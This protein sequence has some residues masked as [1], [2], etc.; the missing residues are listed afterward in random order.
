MAEETDPDAPLRRRMLALGAFWFL[1]MGPLGL[2]LPYYGL[3]LR[4]NAGLSGSEVGAI[5]A[6][7]PLVAMAGQTLWGVTADRSGM[8]ARVLVVLCGGCAAGYLAVGAAGGFLALIGATALLA[9]FQRSLIPLSLSVS[10]PGLADH[11]HAFGVVRALGTIGFGVAMFAFPTLLARWQGAHGL[12]PVAGGPSQPGLGLL[13]P[14][15]AG[16]AGAAALAALALPRGGVLALR[17]APGDWRALLRHRP[18]R[19]LLLVCAAAFLFQNG[20]LEIFPIFVRSRGG[21]LDTLRSLWLFMLVPEVVGV[22]L[23]GVVTGRL[24]PRAL[25]VFGVAAGGLRWLGSAEVHSLSWL[26]PLQSLHAAVVVGL[27]LGGP[28]YLDAIV[29]P[30]LRSTAQALL[31]VAAV[32]LGGASS[33]LLSGWLLQHAGPTAPYVVAGAG[34]LLLAA[35]IPRVLPALAVPAEEGAAG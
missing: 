21:D 34:S 4:E 25:L 26:H 9:V 5:F 20:P 32:G 13:F 19:R 31:G 1:M 29:P 35:A 28:L 14:V 18:Y 22:S 33:S 17:A 16:L 6:V 24:G 8:R 23:L 27:M 11:P 3:Y 30:Q 15:A 7:M 12:L 10:I 2:L